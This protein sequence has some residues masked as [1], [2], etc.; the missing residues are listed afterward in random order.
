MPGRAQAFH[1]VAMGT[2]CRWSD[3]T[4]GKH[5]NQVGTFPA[6]HGRDAGRPSL[7]KAL[8]R[9]YP[10][11]TSAGMTAHKVDSVWMPSYESNQRS[12]NHN[13]SL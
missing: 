1:I 13:K 12:N 10:L 2:S 3:G 7:L 6:N 9:S 11:P 5:V 4:A 8:H